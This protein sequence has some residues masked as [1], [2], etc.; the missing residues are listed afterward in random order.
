M[1][2]YNGIEISEHFPSQDIPE[3]SRIPLP[4]PY[5][6]TP[7]ELID[8]SIGRQLFVDDF[9]IESTD[10]QRTEHRP[11]S[12]AG[13]PIF[14]PE[15][16]WETG[17]PKRTYEEHRPPSVSPSMGGVWYDGQ[18]K[19]Y[20]LWYMASFFG[21]V[22]Y[23]E[24][25]DGVHFNR[26]DTGIYENSN[27][28]MPRGGSFFDTN[29]VVLNRYGQENYEDDFVMSLYVRPVKCERIGVNVYTSADGV[30]WTY[31]AHTAGCD[32]T[33]TV[34]YNPFRRK[35]VYSIKKNDRYFGRRREYS[36]CDDLTAGRAMENRVFFQRTDELDMEHPHWRL[37]PE[38][39]VFHA[40]A[41]ESMML[42]AYTIFKGPQN[43]VSMQRGLPKHTEMHIGYSRD[44]FHFSRQQNRTAFIAPHPGEGR[45]DEGYVHFN[46]A[47]CTVAE[48]L[49][50]F[51][52]SAF[53]G[54]AAKQNA[55][56]PELNGMYA[57]GSLGM[58]TLRRD[59]FASM[60]GTGTLQTRKLVFDGEFVFVNAA[61]QHLQVEV[62]DENGQPISGYERENC[63]P[64][65]GDSCRQRIS[66]RENA[67]LKALKGRIIRLVFYQ[68]KGQLFAFWISGTED[69]ESK[70]YL[71]G[72]M[73]GRETLQDKGAV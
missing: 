16:P 38:L 7:P 17:E 12:Y 13:N 68:Q 1:K 33:T 25:S 28:V 32:D 48:E 36:E 2:L 43:E 60:Q 39:Y 59:G 62:Q 14:T 65:T 9:L 29:C 11:Q 71:A 35:W 8:I 55:D 15:M 23:A 57:N 53:R 20:K 18:E 67:S 69:G 10:L 73:P 40:V 42:G 70:G 21:S 56:A 34:F 31:R 63:V 19:K 46:S 26:P 24:S 41:Y 49:L 27:I 47:I 58:A 6:E 4:V 37:K 50:T 45:W 64:F 51:Y 54:D 66:W 72:G 44:G 3:N 30:H 61:A 52:Y 5:L 22:A